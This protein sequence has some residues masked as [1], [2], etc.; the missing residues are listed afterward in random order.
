VLAGEAPDTRSCFIHRD[1]HEGNTLEEDDRVVSVTD[2]VTAAWGPPGIDLA[3][4]RLNLERFE[5]WVA[6]IL[7]EL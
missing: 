3:R 4:M 6:G 2:W 5:S 1:Y 7:G